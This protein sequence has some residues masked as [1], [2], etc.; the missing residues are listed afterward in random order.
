MIEDEVTSRMFDR[1]ALEDVHLVDDDDLT[2][3]QE[4]FLDGQPIVPTVT[5]VHRCLEDAE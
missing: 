2:A 3:A 5:V 1:S 4:Q